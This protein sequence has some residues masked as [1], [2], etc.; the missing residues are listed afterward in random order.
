MRKPVTAKLISAFFCTSCLV[1]YLYFLNTKFQA[2]SHLQWLYS[3]VC[4][5]IHIVGFLTLRLITLIK[6]LF[7]FIFQW[8]TEIILLNVAWHRR[9]HCSYSHTYDLLVC[10]YINSGGV[11]TCNQKIPHGRIGS[12][13]CQEHCLYYCDRG[14]EES[15]KLRMLKCSINNIW[16][17]AY[18]DRYVSEN[19]L[20]YGKIFL[21][22]LA[23]FL[24]LVSFVSFHSSQELIYVSASFFS[25]FLSFF[26]SF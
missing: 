19:D 13:G 21:F 17:P 14:Y 26:L 7:Q 6:R 4:V 25:L 16:A 11:G 2:S 10:F 12:P 15:V 20:C 24:Y 23:F 1:Q 9:L 18:E 22:H 5:R 3:L 8:N